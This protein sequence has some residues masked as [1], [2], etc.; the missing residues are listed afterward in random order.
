MKLFWRLIWIN[1]WRVYRKT[2]NLVKAVARRAGVR[3]KNITHLEVLQDKERIKIKVNDRV[4]YHPEPKGS[5]APE[6]L[7]GVQERDEPDER[8]RLQVEAWKR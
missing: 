1:H 5:T 7:G 8:Q 4:E 6:S 2:S 3:T